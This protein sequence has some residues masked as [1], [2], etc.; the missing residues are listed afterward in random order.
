MGVFGLCTE[1]RCRATVLSVHLTAASLFV[2]SPV[3]L[4]NASPSD[5]QSYVIWGS[6]LLVEDLKVAVLDIRS[7][8]FGRWGFPLDF[9]CCA[10]SGVY[11]ESMS[12]SLLPDL[13]WLFFSVSWYVGI[14]QLVSEILV[15]GLIHG[16]AVYLVRAW[17]KGTPEAFSV[18]ILFW[19]LK[20]Y[21]MFLN[22][23]NRINIASIISN[24][25]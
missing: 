9:T 10:N 4:M 20:S 13:M 14:T 5:V 18:T 2:N 1:P 17:E 23:I 12:Q 7:K 22:G 24:Y 3:R 25:I 8:C 11:G 19:S 6:F 16:V 21:S 15:E